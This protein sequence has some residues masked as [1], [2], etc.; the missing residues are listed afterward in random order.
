MHDDIPP[1][2]LFKD[3][4][5]FI[6]LLCNI[7]KVYLCKKI[8]RHAASWLFVVSNVRDDSRPHCGSGYAGRETVKQKS[9]AF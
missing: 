2:S 1:F 6:I 3:I 7:R 5:P 8:S 4:V 9:P